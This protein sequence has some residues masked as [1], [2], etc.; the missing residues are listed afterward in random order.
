MTPLIS[1]KLVTMIILFIMGNTE[2]IQLLRKACWSFDQK[3][4]IYNPFRHYKI[5]SF[6]SLTH[7]LFN[8]VLRN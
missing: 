4:K 7:I 6:Y 8:K 3:Y 5:N 1:L 2:S